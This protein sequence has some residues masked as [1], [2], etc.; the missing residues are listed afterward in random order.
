MSAALHISPG[1]PLMVY[2]KQ[3]PPPLLQYEPRRWHVVIWH[4]MSVRRHATVHGWTYTVRSTSGHAY[5][6]NYWMSPQFAYKDSSIDQFI[7]HVETSPWTA[8]NRLTSTKVRRR[9]FT[10]WSKFL[11][12]WRHFVMNGTPHNEFQLQFVN[13]IPPIAQQFYVL[14]RQVSTNSIQPPIKVLQMEEES[15][16]T[17]KEG[18]LRLWVA[19]NVEHPYRYVRKTNP[20]RTMEVKL[21]PDVP[22]HPRL[23]TPFPFE[24]SPEESNFIPPPIVDEKYKCQCSIREVEWSP[25]DR[26]SNRPRTGR[27]SRT[28]LCKT[29]GLTF[30]TCQV[31]PFHLRSCAR[32]T[33]VQPTTIISTILLVHYSTGYTPSYTFYILISNS[34]RP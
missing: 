25:E 4:P 22:H 19:T 23:V 8:H 6:S 15:P 31:L 3:S 1:P 11:V 26:Q 12:S 16:P 32:R 2:R 5:H 24:W 33:T 28:G 30:S 14:C 10:D 20:R 18:S 29:M 13:E 9:K 21:S 27:T 34:L 7:Y 17:A